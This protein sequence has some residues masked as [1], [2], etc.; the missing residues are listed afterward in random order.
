MTVKNI[1][2]QQAIDSREVAEM[3]EKQHKNLLADIRGYIKIME[4]TNGLNF[5]PVDFFIESSYV[6]GKGET[7][8]CYL[9]TK[10]GC[11]MIANKLTGE[12][13][14][15]FTA[16]YVTAF[17]EMQKMLSLPYQNPA[18]FPPKCTSAGE[19]ASLLRELRQTMKE[20]KR[21]SETVSRQV[22]TTCQQLGW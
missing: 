1:N 10:K 18:F 17:E 5:Q 20:N 7:R 8:P 19:V 4:K 6:D 13:G 12:K 21:P 14:V 2:G 3:V 22:E 9:I 15:L 16:A 11:D